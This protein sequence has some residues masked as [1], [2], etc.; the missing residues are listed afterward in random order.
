MK[1]IA[2]IDVMPLKELL[3]PQGKTVSG[4]LQ[5]LSISNVH[6]VRVGKHII[7]KFD[8]AGKEEASAKV[9]TACKQLLVNP[10]IEYYEYTVKEEAAVGKE[11]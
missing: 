3:D 9:E 11:S 4:A 6:D 10:V 1:F 7:M 2:E 5:K 8:A